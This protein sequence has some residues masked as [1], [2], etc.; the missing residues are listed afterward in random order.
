[1]NLRIGGAELQRIMII[2]ESWLLHSIALQAVPSYLVSSPW[3]PCARS[4]VS[5][6]AGNLGKFKIWKSFGETNERE[7]EE[8]ER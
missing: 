6:D 8:T 1:M 4:S 5:P 3:Q 7:K 2:L